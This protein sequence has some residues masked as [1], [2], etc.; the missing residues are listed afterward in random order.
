MQ[1]NGHDAGL[2]NEF[3]DFPHFR[4]V[5][6]QDRGDERRQQRG[7]PRGLFRQDEIAGRETLADQET[8]GVRSG[9]DRGF[10][11]V[12][13]SDPADFNAHD[14]TPRVSGCRG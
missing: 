2:F 10:K 1:L 6:D 13:I 9:I 7:Q 5:S 4:K 12:F 11:F 3:H 8:R 14:A